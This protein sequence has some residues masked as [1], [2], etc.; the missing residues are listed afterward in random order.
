MTVIAGFNMMG[1]AALVGDLLASRQTSQSTYVPVPMV[2]DQH[3]ALWRRLGYRMLGLSVEDE[4]GHKPVEDSL[5][6]DVAPRSVA[7]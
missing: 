6:R 7:D 2:T 4:R 3:G 1:R 5:C